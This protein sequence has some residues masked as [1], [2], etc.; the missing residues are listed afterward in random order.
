M[1]KIVLIGW[2][3]GFNK[4]QFNHFLQ[5]RCEMGLADAKRSVDQ[6]LDG[7]RVELDF[8]EF[9]QVD[10]QRMTELGVKFQLLEPQQ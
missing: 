9:S 4:V 8:E 2:R 3:E 5:S 6:V 1:T 10:E 7:E